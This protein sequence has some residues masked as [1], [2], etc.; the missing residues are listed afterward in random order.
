MMVFRWKDVQEIDKFH[1]L[2]VPV[3]VLSGY[4][5]DALYVIF[6]LFSLAIGQDLPCQILEYH[7]SRF[8]VHQEH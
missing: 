6:G 3:E 5:L 1:H 2:S 8:Q 4:G 7:G